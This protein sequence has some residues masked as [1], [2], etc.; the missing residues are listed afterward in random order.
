MASSHPNYD[1]HTYLTVALAP[2]SP[3]LAAPSQL[4]ARHPGLVYL[5]PVGELHDVQVVGVQKDVRA[6]SA[7]P[8]V[9]ALTDGEGVLRV[10]VQEP[11][12][13]Q[14]RISLRETNERFEA[15]MDPLP[16]DPDPDGYLTLAG[17]QLECR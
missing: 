11:R 8:I 1:T 2:S 13:I 14:R 6:Q 12:H 10:A 9:N 16:P 15:W 17:G 7:G 3:L 5:G 4:T